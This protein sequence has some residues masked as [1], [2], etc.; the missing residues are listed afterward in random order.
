VRERKRNRE[1]ENESGRERGRREKKGNN[2]REREI[3]KER[4]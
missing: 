4:R 1:I 2:R 3:R